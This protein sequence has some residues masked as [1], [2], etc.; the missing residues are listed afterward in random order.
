MLYPSFDS[1]NIHTLLA[2]ISVDILLSGKFNYL[3]RHTVVT[4]V[5][6]GNII[7]K[8]KI[9]SRHNLLKLKT[10]LIFVRICLFVLFEHCGIIELCFKNDQTLC[11]YFDH[12]ASVQWLLV[13]ILF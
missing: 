11:T 4:M 3:D 2:F 13:L 12:C 10:L 1:K 5:L 8:K 7:E 9:C 6:E